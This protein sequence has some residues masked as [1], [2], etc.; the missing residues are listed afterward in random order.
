MPAVVAGAAAEDCPLVVVNKA[1]CDMSGY[2]SE[3]LIGVNCRFLQPPIDADLVRKR[4]RAFLADDSLFQGE[5]V[6]PNA[7]KDGSRFLNLLH[8]SKLSRSDRAPLIFGSQFDITTRSTDELASYNASL[9]YHTRLIG[10]LVE[11]SGWSMTQPH[12]AL[13]DSLDRIAQYEL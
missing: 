5:F 6:I 8:L 4:I 11:Q 13:A 12:A 2:S 7:R 1:F 10:K 9:R 3:E